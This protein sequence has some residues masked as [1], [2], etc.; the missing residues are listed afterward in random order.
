MWEEIS[1]IIPNKLYLTG[2]RGTSNIKQ[3]FSKFC[4]LI[5]ENKDKKF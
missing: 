2:Y 1:K 5:G 3:Y 4:K